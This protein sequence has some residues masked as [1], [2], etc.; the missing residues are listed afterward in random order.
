MSKIDYQKK[1]DKTTNNICKIL[2][3][4]TAKIDFNYELISKKLD[5][6]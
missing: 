2:E 5:F 1:M 4:R 6:G 3:K